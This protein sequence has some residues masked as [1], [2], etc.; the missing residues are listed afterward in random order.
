VLL[1]IMTV[2]AAGTAGLVAVWALGFRYLWRRGKP[3]EEP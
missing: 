1:R 2:T 3:L